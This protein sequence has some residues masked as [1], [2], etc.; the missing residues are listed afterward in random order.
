MHTY[1]RIITSKKHKN[2]QN[3]NL[4]YFDRYDLFRNC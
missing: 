3:I 1:N 2:E 4:Q